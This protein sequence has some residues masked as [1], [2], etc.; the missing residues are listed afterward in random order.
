MLQ[1]SGS[2]LVHGSP[3]GHLNRFQIY[4]A[5]LSQASK[6]DRQQ[7]SYFFGDLLLD[8]LGRFFS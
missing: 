8:R 3:R 4:L 1:G 5:A 2:G 6:D 7:R